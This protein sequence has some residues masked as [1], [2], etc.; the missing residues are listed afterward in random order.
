[1]AIARV[2]T[3]AD[4][5]AWQRFQLWVETDAA[6]LGMD[7]GT[8]YGVCAVVGLIQGY[9]FGRCIVAAL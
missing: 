1:M 5:S 3:D 8:Y 4:L 9:G 2:W 7:L 6:L